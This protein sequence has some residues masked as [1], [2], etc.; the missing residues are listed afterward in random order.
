MRLW[1]AALVLFARLAHAAPSDLVARPIVLAQGQLDIELTAE[2]DAAYGKPISL[3]P[4]AWF[5]ATPRLT[6]GIVHSGPA[7]DRIEPGA[8]L[9]VVT[10]LP[11]CSQLYRGSGADALWLAYD[12][13]ALAIAPRVRLLLRDV[14]PMKPAATLGGLARWTRG[15][16]AVW[17][18]PYVQLG[19]ANTGDGNRAALFVPIG[20]SVQPGCRWSIDARTGFDSDFAV[21]RDGWYV[22]ASIGARVRA[23]SHVD[24]GAM[25]GFFSALG[26]QNNATQR[27]V[28]VTAGWRS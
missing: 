27:A 16:W 6:I 10:G 9:C 23:T 3:A 5:G 18:D 11:G 19:L 13:G 25:L 2:I 17:A 26:P 12:D 24:V 7:I 4:D 22:P 1:I 28:F 21:I 20:V 14:D 15:R 8:S